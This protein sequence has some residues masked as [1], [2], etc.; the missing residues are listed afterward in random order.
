VRSKLI[1]SAAALATIAGGAMAATAVFGDDNGTRP[2]YATVEVEMSGPSAAPTGKPLARAKK[3]KKPKVLYFSGQGAVDVAAT[4]PYVDVKL[5]AKPENACPRVIDG[6]VQVANLDVYEQGSSVGPGPGE[7]HV[8]IAFEDNTPPVNY[9]FT[10]HL[11]C[12]K[13]V[14]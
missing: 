10:S 11:I 14:N 6:G 7:Y 13:N 12:L 3:A 5:T 2:P 8:L 1:A 9:T 4:G